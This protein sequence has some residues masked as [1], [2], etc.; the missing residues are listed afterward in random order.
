MTAM[1]H[2][3]LPLPAPDVIE[4][5]ELPV[6]MTGDWQQSMTHRDSRAQPRVEAVRGRREPQ[7]EVVHLD[8]PRTT[9]LA[10]FL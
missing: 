7:L 1:N 2:A 6:E 3:F 5:L 8:T 10:L 9:T 4:L